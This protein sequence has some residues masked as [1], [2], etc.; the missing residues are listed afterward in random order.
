VATETWHPFSGRT[1]HQSGPWNK[2]HTFEHGL[3]CTMPRYY[4]AKTPYI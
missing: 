1:H 4:R 2:Y 3:L